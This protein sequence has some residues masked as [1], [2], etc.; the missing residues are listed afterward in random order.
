MA[1]VEVLIRSSSA[2]ETVIGGSAHAESPEW[3]PASSMCSITPARYI[4]VPS[5]NASTS[6][7]IASSRNLSISSGG[8]S[9][10][11]PTAAASASA[12]S[13]YPASW[14]SEYTISMPR[15]PS[16]YDGRTRTG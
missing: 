3:M 9:P 10:A 6:S 12:R 4:S 1:S 11:R 16:T 14:A 7:S 5:N 2:T 8:I 15:P 13:T